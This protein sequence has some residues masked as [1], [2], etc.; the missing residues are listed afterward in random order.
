VGAQNRG[1]AIDTG[2]RFVTS[3]P[4]DLLEREIQYALKPDLRNFYHPLMRQCQLFT[5]RGDKKCELPLLADYH[6]TSSLKS[7]FIIP[8]IHPKMAA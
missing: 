5:M 6:L 4:H 1:I 8:K 2:F 3:A 7:R